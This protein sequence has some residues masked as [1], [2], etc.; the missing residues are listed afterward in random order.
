MTSTAPAPSSSNAPQ[1]AATALMAITDSW[2]DEFARLAEPDS[3]ARRYAT[4]L[5]VAYKDDFS[6]RRAIEDRRR[7]ESLEPGQ[8]DVRLTGHPTEPAVEHCLT[9]YSLGERTLLSDILPIFGSLGMGVVDERPHHLTRTDG[10]RVW[11]YDFGIESVPRAQHAAAG[12]AEPSPRPDLDGDIG[13][14]VC[15]A[16]AAAWTGRADI[17][18]FNALVLTAGLTWRQAE[19][20]RAY[21]KYL[22]QAGFS[23]GHSRL[24][25]VLNTHPG[26]AASLWELF[27]TRLSPAASA[28]DAGVDALH[29]ELTTYIDAVPNLEE[30]TILRA[31]LTLVTATTRTNYFRSD[32]DGTLRSPA[33]S[34]KFD[35]RSLDELIPEP[36]P[37]HEVF[38]FSPRVEGVHLR[39]GRVARGGLRWSDRLDDYRTE[40]LGLVKAQAVK[41]AV[42]VPVGA[43]GGFVVKAPHRGGGTDTDRDARMRTVTN[44]YREFIAA[45]LDITDNIDAATGTPRSTTG[46]RALDDPD[47]YLVVAADKG[48]AAFSDIANDVA[49]DYGFWLGD[50]FAS[51]GSVGYDHKA[52]GITAKG[53]WESVKRHFAEMNV[54]TQT[55]DFR[56]VGIGDMSG[57]V[58]GNGMLLSRHITLIGAFDHRHIFLDPTPDPTRSWQERKRLFDLPRSSWAD[59]DP[60]LISTGG[61]VFDRAAKSID[62]TDTIRTA[63][64][65]APTLR[66]LTPNELIKAILCAPV[67]LLWNGGIGTY[68]KAAT[69]THRDVG[70]KANDAVRVD[71]TQIRAAV[72]GEGGNLGVTTAGRIEYARAAGRINT[73]A[74]D[75]AAGVD[76]SDHEVNIKILLDDLVTTNAIDPDRRD[77]LLRQMTD[78]VER[79]VLASNISQNQLMGSLREHAADRLLVH[80]RQIDALVTDHNLNR[81]LEG[82]PSAEEIDLRATHG[83]GLTSPELA[84]LTAH[85][86]LNLKAQILA[87]D[88]ID[89][90]S[91]NGR[92]LGYFPRRLQTEYREAIL[93][94]SLRREITATVLTNEIV[95][96]AG[97]SYV[98]RLC[99]DT[100]ITV[101]DAVRAFIAASAIADISSLATT[102]TSGT[103]NARATNTSRML[104]RQLLDR[105]SRWLLSNRPQ[106]LAINAEIRRY[107]NAYKQLLPQLPAWLH[108]DQRAELVSTAAKLEAEG[109]NPHL[110]TELAALP[111]S[112]DTLDIVDVA[113]SENR[114]VLEVAELYYALSDHLSVHRA[115]AALD[116]IDDTDR[117]GGLAQQTLHASVHTTMKLITADVLH[118]SIDSDS[119]DTKV[120]EWEHI[121]QSRLHRTRAILD[122]IFGAARRDLPALLVATDQLRAMAGLV[123]RTVTAPAPHDTDS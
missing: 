10:R 22:R 101:A 18:P 72:I 56:V 53:A 88:V 25:K 69:Q 4:R 116:S 82:L 108:G 64:D 123:D 39:F 107:G 11:V 57:D 41:N 38:V 59:Y 45:L 73:D 42:I 63:L 77:D 122:Q 55:Q 89:G 100:G 75:N 78:D 87:S 58:F 28:T 68:V 102:S 6:P 51:G 26:M 61:G 81:E 37:A 40:I 97:I 47:S 91:C 74:L 71:A 33:L 8:I 96:T 14:R 15:D 103:T 46:V 105:L 106:P 79:L 93:H 49:A 30:D 70:D 120:A 12:H 76:C 62:L 52:I 121:N 2:D 99:E 113:D 65:L 23:H 34:L 3:E 110:A 117:W 32:T 9:I 17:D 95:D 83:Q 50:A 24:A 31:Y 1:K 16:F 98:F 19:L 67:D 112:F 48:T 43:K 109:I 94:H 13:A 5:P 114:D 35:T 20:L 90:E 54:D 27:R 29:S 66:A 84:T 60:T 36:R 86:K 118:G 80:A 44:C 104:V 92:L 7:I 115:H 119:T 21:A 85:I 111:Y